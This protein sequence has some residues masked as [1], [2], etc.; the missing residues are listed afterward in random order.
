MKRRFFVFSLSLAVCVAMLCAVGFQ[1]REIQ[2]ARA[3]QERKVAEATAQTNNSVLPDPSLAPSLAVPRELLQ[4]RSQAGQLRRQRD[5]LLPVRAE[6]ERLL[7]QLAAGGTNAS[8]L[9]ANYIRKAQARLVGY[10]T[11]EDTLQSFLWAVHNH[12]TT[13]F[14]RA[15]TPEQSHWYQA[16]TQRYG[17]FAKLFDN[18][19]IFIG[20]SI[21]NTQ[22]IDGTTIQADLQLAPG[23]PPIPVNLQ[24]IENQWKISSF[25]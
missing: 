23:L 25:P 12:D 18:S 17:T 21:V 8:A 22:R 14:L 6:H 24:Q 1:R 5:E 2:T 11:P 7:L 19:E 15:L 13:N 16:D 20:F 10:S 9:P 4:L 3:E